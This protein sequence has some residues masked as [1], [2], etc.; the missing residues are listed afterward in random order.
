MARE[1]A[2]SVAIDQLSSMAFKF[3]ISFAIAWAFVSDWG[4]RAGRR[5]QRNLFRT[6]VLWDA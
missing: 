6:I 2:L 4:G 3:T 5:A 1:K